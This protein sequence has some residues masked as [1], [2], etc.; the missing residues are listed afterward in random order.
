MFSFFML[1]L[2]SAMLGVFVSLDLFLFYM[3]W[4]RC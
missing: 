2:E 1:A 4:E 3:F